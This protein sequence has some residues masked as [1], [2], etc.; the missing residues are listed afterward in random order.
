MDR[1]PDL[2]LFAFRTFQLLVTEPE[3]RK[4]SKERVIG[5]R[6][7]FAQILPQLYAARIV[8]GRMGGVAVVKPE[9]A[10]ALILKEWPAFVAE[11]EERHVAAAKEI[12]GKGSEK[13]LWRK[14]LNIRRETR[15]IAQRVEQYFERVSLGE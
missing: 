7:G 12:F 9:D 8:A 15:E 10:A 11:V 2:F 3:K 14:K 1:N 4:K 5:D 6:F 13:K